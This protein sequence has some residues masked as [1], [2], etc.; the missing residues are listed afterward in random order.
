M[1]LAIIAAEPMF[2]A[3]LS[4]GPIPEPIPRR[5]WIA[6]AVVWLGVSAIVVGQPGAA[7]L[8]GGGAALGASL[9]AASLFVVARRDARWTR[10]GR[11]RS[12]PC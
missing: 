10:S 12:A 3:L 11:R 1:A 9:A 6:A 7:A 5:T 8:A 4:R 2:A